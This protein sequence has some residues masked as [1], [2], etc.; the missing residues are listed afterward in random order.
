MP[1]FFPRLIAEDLM[2]LKG[3]SLGDHTDVVTTL[4]GRLDEFGDAM[5]VNHLNAY[6]TAACLWDTATGLRWAERLA[7]LRRSG[8]AGQGRHDR[9]NGADTRVDTK[10]RGESV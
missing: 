6:V 8:H 2:A 10:S 4:P 1:T 5:S 7:T 3:I 9:G